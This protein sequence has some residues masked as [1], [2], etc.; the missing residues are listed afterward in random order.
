MLQRLN[1]PTVGVIKNFQGYAKAGLRWVTPAIVL[2]NGLTEQAIGNALAAVVVAG[3]VPG[4]RYCPPCLDVLEE[5]NKKLTE[6]LQAEED[7]V[8]HLNKLKQKL[9]AN[10]DEVGNCVLITQNCEI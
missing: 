5:G 8:N 3:A 1:G 4:S 7:K 9:E 2:P 6:D 10:L